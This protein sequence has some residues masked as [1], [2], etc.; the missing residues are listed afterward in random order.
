M[1]VN[2]A[3]GWQ[4]QLGALGS[5]TPGIPGGA[6]A[7]RAGG[8]GSSGPWDPRHGGGGGAHLGRGGGGQLGAGGYARW[9][10]Q[11]GALGS[12]TRTTRIFP[13]PSAMRWQGQLGALGSET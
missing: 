7:R 1:I 5:E 11:L 3:G 12:E 13:T 8:K 2:T 6:S 10:G 9:Q 4:G